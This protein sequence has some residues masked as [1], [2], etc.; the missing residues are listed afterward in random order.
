M[1]QFNHWKCQH[2]QQN[3]LE[4]RI[5]YIVIVTVPKLQIYTHRNLRKI[6]EKSQPL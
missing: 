3:T 1:N 5:K 2:Q 6:K 4:V